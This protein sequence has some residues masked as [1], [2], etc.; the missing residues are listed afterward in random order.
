MGI[1]LLHR[2]DQLIITTIEIIDELG[3]QGLSTRE[4][5][6]RQHVSEATLF[7]HYKSKND[8]LLA[9]LDSFSKFDDDIFESTRFKNIGSIEAILYFIGAYT[10]Y[11]EGY[12]A[13]TAII[14][15]IDVFRYEPDLVEKVTHIVNQRFNF[16]K[17][18][19]EEAQRTGE[20]RSEASSESLSLILTGIVRETCL[21]WRIKGKSFRLKEQTLTSVEMVLNAFRNS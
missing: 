11:Y 21:R 13:I 6:K 17:Q 19:I 8:L 14:Q 10:E 2:K 16:L 15:L 9:V 1:N 4:I 5:A 7:R 20:L 12:P 18:I 3:I